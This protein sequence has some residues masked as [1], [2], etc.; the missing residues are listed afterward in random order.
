MRKVLICVLVSLLFAVSVEAATLTPEML[1][2]VEAYITDALP[3]FNVPGAAVA[4]VQDGSVIYTGGFGTLSLDD[5]T[6]VNS[7]TLFMI[8][9]TTKPMTA[10]MIGSLV[11]DGILD[12]DA[13]ATNYL[14]AFALG[15]PAVTEQIRVRDLL[16]MSSGVPRFD[17]PLWLEKLSVEELIAWMHEIP[18]VSEPGEEHHYSNMMVAVGGY[19][20]AQAVG[21]DAT[22]SRLMHERIFEPVGMTQTTCEMAD[23][24]TNPNH[25]LPTRYDLNAETWIIGDL[26]FNL[27]I[28]SAAPAGAIWSNAEDMGRFLA[29]IMRGGVTP[30]GQR[31]ISEAS[32]A[33]IQEPVSSL[34]SYG[35]GW[36]LADYY[37]TPMVGHGGDIAGFSTLFEYLPEHQIGVVV[38]S[39]R[40]LSQAFMQAVRDRVFNLALRLS[41]APQ[42]A[43]VDADAQF[44]DYVKSAVTLRE[45]EPIIGSPFIGEYEHHLTITP[46]ENGTLLARTEITEF[47]LIWSGE[48]GE[49]AGDGDGLGFRF[50]FEEDNA[51]RMTVRIQDV[52]LPSIGEVVPP[53]V[54]EKVR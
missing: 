2:E 52:I 36:S 43:Y 26:D 3:H 14:P 28:E 39:N 33:E 48:G 31:I 10:T 29:T 41:S 17:Y 40:L 21:G 49:F 11:D 15:D 30:D 54:L 7:E 27:Y 24:L 34:Q 32:L 6:A 8:G 13:P 4:V 25:A 20:A 12:W 23:A 37:G 38:L 1:D 16:N 22:Y 50:Y 53:L 9:S 44:I 46:G 45:S 18:L 42:E 19:L 35:M 51:G 5:P 47:P